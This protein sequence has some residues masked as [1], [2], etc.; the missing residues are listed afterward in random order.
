MLIKTL[1]AAVLSASLALTSLAP[2][3]VQAGLSDE[4]KIA[5]LLTLFL[6]G[7]AISRHN[8]RPVNAD[9]RTPQANPPRGHSDWRVLPSE[10]RMQ[11]TSRRG[12]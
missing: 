2:T 10:C 1:T 11:A 7:A 6:L 9:P 8:D 12:E 4:E 5:G 3:P